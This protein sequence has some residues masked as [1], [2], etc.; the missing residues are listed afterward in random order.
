MKHTEK[1]DLDTLKTIETYR[2]LAIAARKNNA[3]YSTLHKVCSG[4]RKSAYGFGWR[5]V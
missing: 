5:F 3:D 4:K 2:T 1:Y